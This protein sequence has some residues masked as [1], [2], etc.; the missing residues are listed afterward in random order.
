MEQCSQPS[1]QSTREEVVFTVQKNN[2]IIIRVWQ[3]ELVHI[4]V[5]FLCLVWL[6]CVCFL[7]CFPYWNNMH[8]NISEGQFNRWNNSLNRT[9]EDVGLVRHLASINKLQMADLNIKQWYQGKKFWL[10]F[11]VLMCLVS[12]LLRKTEGDNSWTK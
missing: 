6:F 9:H 5:L 10:Q 1:L 2:S 12:D 11:I 3:I 8:L 4:L 7:F